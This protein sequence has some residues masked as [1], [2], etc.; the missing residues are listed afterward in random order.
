MDG[1]G[2][3]MHPEKGRSKKGVCPLMTS[4]DGYYMDESDV[5][6]M[7]LPATISLAGDP[8]TTFLLTISDVHCS[9]SDLSVIRDCEDV[10]QRNRPAIVR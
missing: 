10:L 3:L 7:I 8:L 2:N 9:D 1:T 4:M 6:H 5:K